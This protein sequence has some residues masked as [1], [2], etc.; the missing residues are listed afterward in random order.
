MSTNKRETFTKIPK[1]C[2]K[3]NDILSIGIL[4]LPRAHSFGFVLLNCIFILN[5]ATSRMSLYSLP[6]SPPLQ[7]LF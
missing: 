1:K 6:R 7:L 4:S 5:I 3:K 2:M